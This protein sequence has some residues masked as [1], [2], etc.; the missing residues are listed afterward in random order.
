[1]AEAYTMDASIKPGEL[2]DTGARI[3][4]RVTAGVDDAYLLATCPKN[5]LRLI[6]ERG[7][8]GVAA[9][10]QPGQ[11]VHVAASFDSQAGLRMYLNGKLVAS[12]PCQA[13]PRGAPYAQ[14]GDI[15]TRLREEGL[16]EPAEA[17][18]AELVLSHLQALRERIK[19]ERAGKLPALPPASQMAADRSYI[20]AADRLSDGL[21]R[22][23]AGYEKSEDPR[24]Q[25]IWAVW[26]DMTTA[27]P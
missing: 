26:K 27:K 11:W 5:S 8:L 17:K 16:G 2:P 14:I 9:N 18:Q 25:Q 22:V 15:V 20:Q 6:T 21:K 12:S 24:K 19:L 10:L 23:V 4:D 13:S 3:I 7:H 1:L